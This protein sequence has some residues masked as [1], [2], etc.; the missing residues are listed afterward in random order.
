LL[1]R[2]WRGKA[3]AAAK[4]K[5]RKEG[6]GGGG[7]RRICKIMGKKEEGECGWDGH[8]EWSSIPKAFLGT[9]TSGHLNYTYLPMPT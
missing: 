6:R 5:K 2:I 3:K 7:G 4:V 9:L 8:G 1:D